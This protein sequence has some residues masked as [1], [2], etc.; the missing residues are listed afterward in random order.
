MN[1]M[2]SKLK[3]VF[4]KNFRVFSLVYI[5]LAAYLAI[6]LYFV[7]DLKI[8]KVIVI[9]ISIYIFIVTVSSLFYE[10]YQLRQFKTN[11]I[12]IENF[13]V[14][15]NLKEK[16][17]LNKNIE[18]VSSHLVKVLPELFPGASMDLPIDKL[19]YQVKTKK[20]LSSWGEE[21]EM[22]LSDIDGFK[23]QVILSSKPRRFSFMIDSGNSAINIYKI[24]LAL[25]S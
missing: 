6:T 3:D 12:P 9:V 2:Q 23:T 13:N 17:V 25:T 1:L 16:I 4:I 8:I 20:S 10:Y 19:N 7:F 15:S 11:N 5:F 22:A 14:I 24:K 21:I 18:I